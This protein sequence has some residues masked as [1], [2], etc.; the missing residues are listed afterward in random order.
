MATFTVLARD[1]SYKSYK[2]EAETPEAGYHPGSL[3]D[4]RD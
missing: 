2:V 1:T 3:A 4:P